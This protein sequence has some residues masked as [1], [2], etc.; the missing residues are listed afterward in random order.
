MTSAWH[1]LIYLTFTPRFGPA[2]IRE[3]RAAEG[4][5]ER[6]EMK[7]SRYSEEQI[8]GILKEVSAGRSVREV[9]REYGIAEATFYRWRERYAGL[10]VREARRMGQLE[11]ENRRLKQM[12][13]E[14]SLDK[15]VLKAVIAKNGLRR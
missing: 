2:Y 9:I 3:T 4:A 15:E 14:L 7:K 8:I 12:V 5:A 11:Q 13:A 6:V 1:S 10:E